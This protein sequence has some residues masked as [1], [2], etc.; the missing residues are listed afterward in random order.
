MDGQIP[1]PQKNKKKEK[2]KE[3]EKQCSLVFKSED[4]RQ[5]EEV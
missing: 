3:R 1:H 2:K 4:V 5:T